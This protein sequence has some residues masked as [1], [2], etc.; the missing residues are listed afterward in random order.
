[1]EGILVSL[2]IA[3]AVVF[4]W[5]VQAIF[6]GLEKA[7]SRFS[8]DFE[9]IA[10]YI[11]ARVRALEKKCLMRQAAILTKLAHPFGMSLL[12]ETT[13]VMDEG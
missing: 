7:G 6:H 1:M 4:Y 11:T 9:M 13:M 2:A 5:N 10:C 12:K 8:K 3:I